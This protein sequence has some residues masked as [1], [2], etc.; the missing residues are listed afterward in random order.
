MPPRTGNPFAG[1]GNPGC[2][3]GLLQLTIGVGQLV[4]AIP[5]LIVLGVSRYFDLT[6]VEWLAL[7]I[8]IAIGVGAALLG[9]RLAADRLTTRGPEL[10]AAVK[11]R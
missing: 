3:K 5:V 6:A 4:A 1:S 11:A 9:A 8:G 2:A 7:P 10:L